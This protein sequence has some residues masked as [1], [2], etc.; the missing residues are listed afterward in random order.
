M[1][2]KTTYISFD[3]KEFDTEGSC[4]AWERATT[5][6]EIAEVESEAT[7]LDPHVFLQFLATVLEKYDF[8]RR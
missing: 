3:D 8:V 1:K 6:R 7:G 5:F 4:L 2:T